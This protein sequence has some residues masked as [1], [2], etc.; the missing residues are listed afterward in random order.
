MIVANTS[1]RAAPW[2]D[3]LFAMDRQWWQ[4]YHQEVAQVFRGERFSSNSVGH[5][6]TRMPPGTFKPY[7]NSGAACVSLALSAGAKRIVMLGFDCQRTGGQSHWHGDH[8]RGLGNAGAMPK[9]PAKFQEL[10][11]DAA[12]RAEILNATRD[13]ALTMFERR[14]LEQCLVHP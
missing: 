3:A 14:S 4:E 8:P 2:A 11:S 1:F 7:G 13:T 10:A 12:G 9:W 6:V 5:G